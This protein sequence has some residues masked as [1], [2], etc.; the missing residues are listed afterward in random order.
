[1]G[2]EKKIA[3]FRMP[4]VASS[5]IT[6]EVISRCVILHHGPEEEKRESVRVFRKENPDAFIF[7]F[8]RNPFDRLISAYSYFVSSNLV[9]AKD[10]EDRKEY[11]EPYVDFRD[12]VIRGVGDGLVMD[13][14]HIR[15][16]HLWICDDGRLLTNWLGRYEFLQDDYDAVCGI[17]GWDSCKL[18]V[19]NNSLHMS[20]HAYYDDEM[21]KIVSRV[22]EIDFEM[23]R[24]KKTI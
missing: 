22:Y 14:K 2:D 19:V 12:F 21:I 18:C 8:L 17:L 6:K 3:Y 13:Q 5:C 15:P 24:Y 9:H 16:Q 11:V 10:I 7:T 4:K 20:Y 1:M 23:G